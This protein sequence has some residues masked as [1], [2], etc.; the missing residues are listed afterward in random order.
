MN[1][2]DLFNNKLPSAKPVRT[3]FRAYKMDKAGALCSYFSEDHFTLIEAMD[4]DISRKNLMEEMAICGK[5]HIDTLHITSWDNDHC[6]LKALEW[7]LDELKPTKIET[8][9]YLHNSQSAEDCQALITDYNR[10]AAAKRKE[11][12]VIAVTPEYIKSL[13]KGTALGY[14]NMFYH[15]KTIYTTSN[16][17]STVKF[18]RTGAFNVLSSGDIEHNDIGAYLRQCNKLCRELDVL[19]LPHHGGPVDLMTRKFLERLNPS[20]A[21][22]TSNTANQY[23]HPD[24]TIRRLLHDLRIPLMTTIR[25]DVVIESLGSHV[26]TYKAYDLLSDGKT[27]QN[28]K[29]F[30][31]RKFRLMSMNSDT[32]RDK[33]NHRKTGPRRH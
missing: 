29:T 16:D 4:S 17:N 31:A 22:C 26:K 33:L 8:P 14:T 7:I 19:I 11:A 20:L 25:G 32:I 15:P 28:E 27:T 23:E 30:I 5:N 2:N 1:L 24:P 10:N 13:D 9:G 3:R 21:V 6:E 12:R 18:F